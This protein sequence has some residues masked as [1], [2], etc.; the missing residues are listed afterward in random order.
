MTPA[1]G[2]L[3]EP[4]GTTGICAG[5]GEVGPGVGAPRVEEL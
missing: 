1:P 4:Y 5:P 2:P 3:M